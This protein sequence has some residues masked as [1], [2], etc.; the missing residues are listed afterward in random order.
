MLWEASRAA[1]A[2]QGGAVS[3]QGSQTVVGHVARW[4]G[5]GPSR[6]GEG[7]PAG[8]MRRESGL[9]DKAG[10]IRPRAQPSEA[11]WRRFALT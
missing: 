2:R 7:G 11:P 6:E 4:R 3:G 8:V 5:T 10:L 1:A 9:A